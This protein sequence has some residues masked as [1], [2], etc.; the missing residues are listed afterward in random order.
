MIGDRDVDYLAAKKTGIKCLI[1]GNKFVKKGLGN[2]KNLHS[3]TKSIF[4]S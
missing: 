1:V 3:A 2:Y 4:K